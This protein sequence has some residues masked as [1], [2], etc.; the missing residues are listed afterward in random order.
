MGTAAGMFGIGG[1]A[2]AITPKSS[3]RCTMYCA[4]SDDVAA[5]IGGAV[6]GVV[7]LGTGVY[8]AGSVS[9]GHGA[10]WSA[11]AGEGV[12]FAASASLLGIAM[13]CESY[14]LDL[15]TDIMTPL[16]VIGFLT[17]PLVGSIVG[18]EWSSDANRPSAKTATTSQPLIGWS[19]SF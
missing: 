16:T 13:A 19:G 1:L 17:L 4:G 14:D 8:V 5:V 15:C 11:M 18:Y 3:S 7:G 10:Y 12:G 9:E 6:G 2:Y